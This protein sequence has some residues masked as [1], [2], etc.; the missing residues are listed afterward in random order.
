MVKNKIM[1]KLGVYISLLVALTSSLNLCAGFRAEWNWPKYTIIQ[2]NS[3]ADGD[4]GDEL[5]AWINS[6]GYGQVNDRSIFFDAD[7]DVRGTFTDERALYQFPEDFGFYPNGNN[8]SPSPSVIN[9]TDVTIHYTGTAKG[10]THNFPYTA[11]WTRVIFKQG[12]TVGRSDFF[13]N[14]NYIFNFN[15]VTL[16][17]YSDGGAGLQAD[18][19]HFQTNVTIRDIKIISTTGKLSFEPGGRQNGDVENII[20]LKLRG[21]AQIVGAL[22]GQG[23][24]RVENLDWDQTNWRFEQRSIDYF[25]INPIKPDSWTTYSGSCSRVK[26]YYTHDVIVMDQ[27]RSPIQGAKVYVYNVTDDIFNYTE[28]SD[29][30]G[31]I[32][33]QEILKI[34]NSRGT[35][36]D[37]GLSNF[38]VTQYDKQYFFQPRN[39]NR[40]YDEDIILI[41]DNNITEPNTTTVASYSEINNAAQLYDR[42]KWWKIQNTTNLKIPSLDKEL[43]TFTASGLELATD[44]D[45][46]IDPL[47]FEAFTVDNVNKILTIRTDKLSPHSKFSKISCSGDVYLQN[48]ASVSIPYVEKDTDSFVKILDVESTDT[49]YFREEASNTLLGKSIGECGISYLSQNANLKLE[50][51]KKNGNS[52]MLLYDMNNSGLDNVF[53]MGVNLLLQDAMFRSTDRE[54]LFSFV[55][56]VS[57]SLENDQQML[58]DILDSLK[59]ITLRTQKRP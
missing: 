8:V 54:K 9:F 28:T 55:N 36:Y 18:Y 57:D 7:F 53:K 52:T 34:D 50:L 23:D 47:H 33:R 1:N 31:N 3:D 15:D 37:C 42:A 43:L 29:S 30:E 13:N 39:F 49:I 21:V 48:G 44:W 27:N 17:S 2:E 46:V 14:G 51:K 6:N 32:P 10:H 20:N 56:E 35:N 22:N 25:I 4:T 40:A 45:L 12:V 19:L 58:N 59:V 5:R 16:V 26:E 41:D 24:F 11:N 38:V